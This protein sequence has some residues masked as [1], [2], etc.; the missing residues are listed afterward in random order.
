MKR[1]SGKTHTQEQLNAWPIKTTQITKPTEQNQ[2]TTATNTI[3]IARISKDITRKNAV[4]NR[5]TW[6]GHR[7]ILNGTIN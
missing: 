2:T 6:N 7:T 4:K 3:P 5:N 1:V